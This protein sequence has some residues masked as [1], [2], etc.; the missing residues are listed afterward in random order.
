MTRR[1]ISVVDDL[2]RATA[3]DL[4][5]VEN[6]A[7][8]LMS[9]LGAEHA[10]GTHPVQRLLSRA[11]DFQ[12]WD[13]LPKNDV[14]DATSGACWFYH[15]H[16]PGGERADADEH[17]HF[18]CFI[19]RRHLA[20]H[21]KL[22]V[23]PARG[24]KSPPLG[25]YI[26]LAMRRDGLPLSWFTIAQPV[27][28]DYFYPSAALHLARDHF[29]FTARGPLAPTTRWLHAMVGLYAPT[30]TRLLDVRDTARTAPAKTE[31]LSAAPADFPAYLDALDTLLAPA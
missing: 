8:H 15:V 3:P 21:G 16:A 6:A 5:R 28:G 11:P 4:A 25:H 22:I 12:Y 27:T 26:A 17:G 9:I 19:H 20:R 24:T 7:T 2:R 14:R 23:G 1:H 10:R 18:H 29:H 31:I 30:I 13:H